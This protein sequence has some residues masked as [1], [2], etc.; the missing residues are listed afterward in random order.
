M[1]ILV[2]QETDWLSRGPHTQHHVFER[3]SRNPNIKITVM[4]YDT[5]TTVQVGYTNSAGQYQINGL[6][7]TQTYDLYANVT[8]KFATNVGVSAGG[9]IT[10]STVL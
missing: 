1:N 3:M 9:T 2:L 6:P 4:E 5:S 7:T 8:K 10:R